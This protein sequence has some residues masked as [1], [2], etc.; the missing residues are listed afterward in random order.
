MINDMDYSTKYRHYICYMDTVQYRI[1]VGDRFIAM[2][3]FHQRHPGRSPNVKVILE[4]DSPPTKI[5]L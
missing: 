1:P 2:Q 5:Y 4:S 3:S